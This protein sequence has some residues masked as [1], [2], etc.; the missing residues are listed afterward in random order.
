MNTELRLFIVLTFM[1]FTQHL[2]SQARAI[3]TFAGMMPLRLH[4]DVNARLVQLEAL[5]N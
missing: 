1:L 3:V 5:I 2:Q 4:A